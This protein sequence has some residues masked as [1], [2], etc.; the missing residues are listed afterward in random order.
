MGGYP[1]GH[2]LIPEQ[3]LLDALLRKQAF[4]SHVVTQMCF[5]ADA[6]AGWVR[7][8]RRAG[9]ELPVVVGLPGVVERRKLAEISLQTGVGAS[10]RYLR[11][12]R[13]QLTALLRGRHY[14]PTGL[15]RAVAG[16]LEEAGLAAAGAHLFTFN[17]LGPTSAWVQS[18][19]GAPGPGG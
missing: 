11:K 19:A 2:P 1:E 18:L 13:R 12:N 17:Q 16:R 15:A 5:D 10:L 14:D 7:S 9:V 4:A 3:D 6:L 8:I